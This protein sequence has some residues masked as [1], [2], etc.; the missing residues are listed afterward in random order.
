MPYTLQ[1]SHQIKRSTTFKV[2]LSP[3]KYIQNRLF[4]SLLR[5]CLSS[6]TRY[7]SKPPIKDIKHE[8]NKFL[9]ENKRVGLVNIL[10]SKKKNQV[11]LHFCVM[12]NLNLKFNYPRIT[13]A[14][15]GNHTN[16]I[17][18]ALMGKLNCLHVNYEN[19]FHSLMCL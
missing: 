5:V 2:Y 10:I 14:K 19:L 16:Q 11:T 6:H 4:H 9:P 13:A 18:F 15:I 3:L 1:K 8:I 7:T 17:T 12:P